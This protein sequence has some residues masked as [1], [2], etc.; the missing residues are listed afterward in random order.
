M[1]AINLVKY[2]GQ[3]LSTVYHYYFLLERRFD[4]DFD[5]DFNFNRLCVRRFITA[6][7]VARSSAAGA[8]VYAVCDITL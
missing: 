8:N 4:F 5:F 2:N 7:A 6:D 3:F 1:A